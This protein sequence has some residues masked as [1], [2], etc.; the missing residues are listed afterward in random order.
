MINFDEF[1]VEERNK[2]KSNNIRIGDRIHIDGLVTTY[3]KFKDW[4]SIYFNVDRVFKVENKKKAKD[5]GLFFDGYVYKLRNHR[6]W[7]DISKAKITK[8]YD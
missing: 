3:Y 8:L 5:I 7:F 1:D 6:P 2:N 4:D